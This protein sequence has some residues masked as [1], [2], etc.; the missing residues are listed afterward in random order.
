MLVLLLARIAFAQADVDKAD[1]SVDPSVAWPAIGCAA[2]GELEGPGEVER[3]V[4]GGVRGSLAS[5]PVREEDDL[6]VGVRVELE[7]PRDARGRGAG[8]AG[9]A[10]PPRR[11]VW[12]AQPPQDSIPTHTWDIGLGLGYLGYRPGIGLF[13]I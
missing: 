12:G 2:L 6:Y 1:L 7:A 5:A 10:Q 8:G 4:C 3:R 11:G 9:G 13:G